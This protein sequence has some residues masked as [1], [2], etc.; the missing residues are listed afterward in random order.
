MLQ[1]SV[2]SPHTTCWLSDF[3][4]L[5]PCRNWTTKERKRERKDFIFIVVVDHHQYYSITPRWDLN[6]HSFLCFFW[7]GGVGSGNILFTCNI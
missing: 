4:Q 2:G 1:S 3:F 5:L 6:L 7:G